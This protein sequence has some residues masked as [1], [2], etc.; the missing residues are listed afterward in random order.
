MN[1]DKIYYH[2]FTKG[3]IRKQEILY[4][5][6]SKEN[7]FYITK[8]NNKDISDNNIIK[9]NNNEK[10]ENIYKA[11]NNRYYSLKFKEKRKSFKAIIKQ[12][13]LGRKIILIL[14]LNLIFRMESKKNILNEKILFHL[15][16][17][18]LKVNG[19]GKHSI[20]Y[21]Y[22]LNK[23]FFPCP[24]KVYINNTEIAIQSP[25]YKI[26]I[27]EPGSIIKLEW[28]NPLSNPHALF[29]NCHNITEINLVNFD[30]SLITNM[31]AFFA[32]CHS[33]TSINLSNINT[34][35][36]TDMRRMFKECYSLKSINLSNFETSKI[37]T[38]FHMFYF[39]K[40]LI[41]LDLSIFDTSEVTNMYQL[42][43]N[44][45]NLE[46]IN[47]KNFSDSKIQNTT[48][49]FTGI[50]QN[51]V[52]CINL[53]KAPIIYEILINMTCVT[54][55]CEENWKSV[56]K[57]IDKEIGKC[58][59][60][61]NSLSNCKTCFNDDNITISSICTSC[62]SD[63]YLNYGKCVD[64]CSNGYFLDE[65]NPS[66]KICKCELTKC[67]LCSNESLFQNLCISCNEEDNYY[68]K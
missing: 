21:D 1:P 4:L 41:S 12:I 40:S 54:I 67:K 51:A 57:K 66:I 55:S 30:T 62:Y 61:C 38:L 9:N 29:A 24:N 13:L 11:I 15:N 45:K 65:I 37:K 20:L 16:E 44:C 3:T 23:N 63:Q 34:K 5:R 43:Y 64:N 59:D 6:A 27:N 18:T 31:Y 35:N 60:N 49:I 8:H 52:I 19:T 14:L 50:A 17:I 46:Y 28:N 10:R 68:P 22:S 2:Q 26:N 39:A 58:I 7:F 25:C 48:D 53:T 32:Y 47:L 42:F 36:V 33:L 56:Q